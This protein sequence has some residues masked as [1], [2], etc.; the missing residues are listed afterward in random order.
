MIK[1]REF[2]AAI[3]RKGGLAPHPPRAHLPTMAEITQT[4]EGRRILRRL[5]AEFSGTKGA[6]PMRDGR[7][8]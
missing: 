8:K 3:G 5:R 6:G 7:K 2:Y 1:T 4:A